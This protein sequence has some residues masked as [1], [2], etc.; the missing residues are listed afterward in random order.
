MEGFLNAM[1]SQLARS[2]GTTQ[3]AKLTSATTGA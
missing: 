2:Y 1:I 3:A